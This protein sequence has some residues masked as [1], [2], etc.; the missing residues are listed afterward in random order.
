MLFK[1]FLEA[2]EENWDLK[3]PI[4][5]PIVNGRSVINDVPN[6]SSIAA[7][8]VHY[9]VL[10]RIRE[11]SMVH[12]GGPRTVF[13]ATDDLQRSRELAEQIEQSKQ[14]SPLI[15]AVDEKGPYLLEG[16]HR[17]V[18]LHYLKATSFPALVVID[19]DD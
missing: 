9:E 14:I 7:S 17:Y 12:F 11:V 19:K 18:A 10:P 4:A 6:T 15:V 13:Y 3:F 16:A 5:G 8:F 1:E 2:T